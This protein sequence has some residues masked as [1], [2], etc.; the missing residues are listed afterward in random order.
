MQRSLL[1]LIMSWKNYRFAGQISTK[2]KIGKLMTAAAN[3]TR[4]KIALSSSWLTVSLFVCFFWRGGGA[5]E[6]HL[7]FRFPY[8]VFPSFFHISKLECN[9]I[10]ADI[11]VSLFA[12]STPLRGVER[13][14]VL[15]VIWKLFLS[16]VSLRDCFQYVYDVMNTWN[17]CL[18]TADWNNL[19]LVHKVQ[20][21]SWRCE[22]K[23]FRSYECRWCGKFYLEL[24]CR[25]N[26]KDEKSFLH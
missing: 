17:S 9:V 16:F 26:Y 14:R 19:F 10:I 11:S 8:L 18:W 15:L 1:L 21:R 2:Q 7:W 20:Q 6:L 3:H 25:K 4:W 22:K 24:H 23:S 13:A 12:I 5:G